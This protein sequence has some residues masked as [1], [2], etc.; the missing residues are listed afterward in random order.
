MD[1]DKVDI[2][3]SVLMQS[4]DSKNGRCLTKQKVIEAVLHL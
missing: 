2:A 3:D 4:K 1:L